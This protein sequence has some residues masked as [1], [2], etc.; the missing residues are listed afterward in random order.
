MGTTAPLGALPPALRQH[1]FSYAQEY[2]LGA[3]SAPGR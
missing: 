3:A 2:F 1:R